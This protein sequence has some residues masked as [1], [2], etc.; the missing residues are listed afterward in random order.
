MKT[1]G[2]SF[3]A[4][5]ILVVTALSAAVAT[6]QDGAQGTQSDDVAMPIDVTGSSPTSIE[7]NLDTGTTQIDTFM[8]GQTNTNSTPQ[9]VEPQRNQPRE[10][11]ERK[12][13]DDATPTQVAPSEGNP[14]NPG[15]SGLSDSSGGSLKELPRT[16]GPVNTGR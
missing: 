13:K 14:T 16:G 1:R 3:V 2:L 12:N 11:R 8:P 10:R 4:F 9:T 6:A 5:A 15:G 7:A